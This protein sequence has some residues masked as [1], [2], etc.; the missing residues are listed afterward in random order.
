MWLLYL[1]RATRRNIPEDAILLKLFAH[2]TINSSHFE[3]F[4]LRDGSIAT[5]QYIHLYL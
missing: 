3:K 4:P 5:D 1:K 2:V